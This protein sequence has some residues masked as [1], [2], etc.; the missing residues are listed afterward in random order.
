MSR[1]APFAAALELLE[2]EVRDRCAFDRGA[3]ERLVRDVDDAPAV[4]A[5]AAPLRDALRILR[6]RRVERPCRRRLPVD[7]EHLLPL[8]V[9]PAPADVERPQRRVE[10]EPAEAQPALGVLEGADTPLRPR[11][12]RDRRELGRHRVAGAL[13]RRA[14]PVEALVRVVDVGLLVLELGVRHGDLTL[15]A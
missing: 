11:L 10:R 4:G 12:H 8:V 5:V 1:I 13:E 15:A 6:R 14:H 2:E 7:D 9:H 3:V